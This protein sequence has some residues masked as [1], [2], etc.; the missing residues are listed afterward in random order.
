MSD[1]ILNFRGEQKNAE[2]PEISSK[3]PL[4][5]KRALQDGFFLED[6]LNFKKWDRNLEFPTSK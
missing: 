6:C 1:F 2:M 4:N 3:T 5:W